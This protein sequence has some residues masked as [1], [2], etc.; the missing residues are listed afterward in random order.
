[1]KSF[2]AAILL[3]AMVIAAPTENAKRGGVCTPAT[4]SCTSDFSGWQVCDVTGNWDV[5]RLWTL[6]IS[7]R[8]SKYT[9]YSISSPAAVHQAL[10]V[11][12]SHQVFRH[13]AF[14][15]DSNFRHKRS[16]TFQRGNHGILGRMLV[17]GKDHTVITW[18]SV[19][20]NDLRY[21]RVIYTFPLS[22]LHCIWT[23]VC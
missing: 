2:I 9:D 10:V 19:C 21:R 4:Y 1:M 14:L 3:A 6:W 12:S 18:V 15:Q 23:L 11:F 8:R 16:T 7:S 22:C 20:I 5:S 13:I 17:V